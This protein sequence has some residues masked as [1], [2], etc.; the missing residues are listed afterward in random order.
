MALICRETT[1][2]ISIAVKVMPKSRRL[3]V[4][5]IAPDIDGERLRIGVSAAPEGGRANAEVC[6][7]LAS[8]LGVAASAIS[9]A[10][11][12]S[13]RQ[14]LL[15]VTGDT[16]ALLARIALFSTELRESTT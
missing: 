1:D 9:V 10:H 7:T 12:A 4:L 5:G 16:P 2:G 6:A 15:R 13:S 8:A 14:K 11:G 3:G